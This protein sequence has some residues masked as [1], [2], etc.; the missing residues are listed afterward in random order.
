MPLSVHEDPAAAPSHKKSRR[1]YQAHYRSLF[2]ACGRD[3]DRKML[4][5][6]RLLDNYARD[7]RVYDVP[8]HAA[9]VRMHAALLRQHHARRIG[10]DS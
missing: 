4:V 10:A 6:Q 9:V 5:G 1:E 2:T 7:A 8:G 3:L